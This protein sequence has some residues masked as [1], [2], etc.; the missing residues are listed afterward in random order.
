MSVELENKQAILLR[1]LTQ[2]FGKDNI[3]FNISLWLLLQD[4]DIELANNVQYKN[5]KCLFTILD[6]NNTPKLVVNFD[7]LYEKEKY[8]D[9]HEFEKHTILEKVL[10]EV[11][12]MY[13]VVNKEDFDGLTH[14]K[15]PVSVIDFINYKLGLDE[16]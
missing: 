13:L 2:V 1:L 8:I 16:E 4:F 12:V 15:H 7:P 5:Y 14:P 3:I 6:K 9:V 10:K 11:S